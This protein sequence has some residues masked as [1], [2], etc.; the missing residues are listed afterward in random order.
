MTTVS[1]SRKR[2][3]PTCDG[4]DPKSC[5]RCRG[6]T[7]LCDWHEWD[8]GYDSWGVVLGVSR[9]KKCGEIAH[10]EHFLPHKEQP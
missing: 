5:A 7:R 6:R 2:G 1:S 10:G 8:H 9:C 3:C 4:V